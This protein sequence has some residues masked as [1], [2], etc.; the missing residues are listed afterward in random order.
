MQK[1]KLI[2][3]GLFAGLFNGFFGS[4]GGVIAVLS[5]ERFFGKE[6]KKCHATAVAVILPLCIVSIFVY[7][8]GGFAD[9][10]IIGK[11]SLGGVIGGFVGA[12]LLSRISPKYIHKIFGVL[13]AVAAVRMVFF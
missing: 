5:L 11:A 12:K 9:W 7:A 13:L 3:C 10:G 1:V 8:R 4:G 2:L 6:T